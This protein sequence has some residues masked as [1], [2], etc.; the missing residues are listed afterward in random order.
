MAGTGHFD[1]DVFNKLT[2]FELAGL[3]IGGTIGFCL[4]LY[5]FP[6][7]EQNNLKGRLLGMLIWLPCM[8]IGDFVGGWVAKWMG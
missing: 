6:A 4:N 8:I 2:G 1:P 7:S 3:A 5:F